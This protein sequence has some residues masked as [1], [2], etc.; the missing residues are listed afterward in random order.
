MLK[1]I[2]VGLEGSLSSEA[3]THMSIE[4]ALTCGAH[5]AG[6]AI[7]DEPD[8]RAGALTGIGGAS[9]KQARDQTLM[10]DARKHADDWI[11]LFERRCREAGVPA[12]GIEIVGRPA[13]SILNE[14]VAHDLTVMGKDANFRFETESDD[15]RTREAI[16]RRATGPVLLV[17]ESAA[18]RLGRVVIVAY[19]GSAAAKRALT[20]FAKSGLAGGREV[21][22][23]TVDDS[24]AQAWEMADRA[25]QMLASDDIPA[26][27]HN[28][29]SVLSNVD[30]LFELAA[31]LGAGLMVMGA[32][33]HRRLRDMFFSGSVTHGLVEKSTIPLYLQH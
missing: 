26:K 11:A 27:P 18:A 12:R 16:L 6:L 24:G 29:V 4:I 31:K 22:V 17:P 8:I 14:M 33:A 21:H 7:V 19:D 28:V 2:L 15:V 20:S 13:D 23:A 5:L 3:A 10:A 32:F 25:V 9:F 1:N 30:A